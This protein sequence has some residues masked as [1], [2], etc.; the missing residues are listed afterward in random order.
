MPPAFGQYEAILK[1]FHLFRLEVITQIAENH[2]E[3]KKAACSK[4]R[5]N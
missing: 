5:G 3:N 2:A 1:V 4:Q